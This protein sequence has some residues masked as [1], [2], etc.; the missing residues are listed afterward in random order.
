MWSN[1]SECS[2][3]CIYHHGNIPTRVRHRSCVSPRPSEDPPGNACQGISLS[4]QQCTALPY[5]AVHGSWGPWSDFS[6]CSVTC[7]V[8][9]QMSTRF[10]NNPPPKHGGQGCQGDASRY[11]ICNTQQ[12]CPVDGVWSEWSSWGPCQDVFDDTYSIN[13]EDIG[14]RQRRQRIC[15][16]RALGGAPCPVQPLSESRACYDVDGCVVGGQWDGWEPWSQCEPPCGVDS[17]RSRRKRCKPD[18]SKYSPTIGIK[19]EPATFFGEP[20]LKCGTP[21]TE[22]QNCVNVPPC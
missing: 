16:H 9:L 5:C 20:R 18:Y 10:C 7:G 14:G 13:C 15:L 3:S 2:G 12:Q 11:Q 8:G 6:P 19:E 1:F 17:K 4:T 22:T 21:A